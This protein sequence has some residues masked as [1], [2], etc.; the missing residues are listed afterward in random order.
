[1]LLTSE[2]VK[3]AIEDARKRK[4]GK[5]L[6]AMEIYEAITQA[7]YNEDIKEVKDGTG[8]KNKDT[9]KPGHQKPD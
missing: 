1:M 7:Q 4:P 8:R 6:A 5:I 9:E 3:Q 2:K